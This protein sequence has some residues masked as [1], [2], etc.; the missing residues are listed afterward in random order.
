MLVLL[1]NPEYIIFPLEMQKLTFTNYGK[2]R[3]K[4]KNK[5]TKYSGNDVFEIWSKNPNS[6]YFMIFITIEEFEEIVD[7]L[8]M[9]ETEVE[10]L[11]FKNKVLLLFY[12]ISQYPTY[13]NISITFNI[14]TSSVSKILGID[15]SFLKFLISNFI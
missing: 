12:F 6:F 5:Y 4:I 11:T 14:S 7:S 1:F 10:E 8:E 15:K 9:R 3:G 2:G 13:Q